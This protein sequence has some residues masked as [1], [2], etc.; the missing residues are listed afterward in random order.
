MPTRTEMDIFL[1]AVI[2]RT[3]V[4]VMMTPMMTNMAYHDDDDAD[5]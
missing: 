4:V 1:P 2:V 5:D 3:L